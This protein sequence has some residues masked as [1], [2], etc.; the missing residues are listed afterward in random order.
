MDT[1]Q[2]YWS[3]WRAHIAAEN[4]E[5]NKQIC[6]ELVQTNVPEAFGMIFSYYGRTCR[7]IISWDGLTATTLQPTYPDDQGGTSLCIPK[8][9]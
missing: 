1:W 9:T 8:G 2:Q 6:W 3:S 5:E 7:G 4:T